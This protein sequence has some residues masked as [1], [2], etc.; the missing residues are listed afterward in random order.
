MATAKD[1]KE[2]LGLSGGDNAPKPAAVKKGKIP[3][4][5][6]LSMFSTG[7]LTDRI[8]NIRLS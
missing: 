4:A 7:Y 5:K 8:A 2:M 6:R 1:V 3:G